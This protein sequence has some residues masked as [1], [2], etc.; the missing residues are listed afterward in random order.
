MHCMSFF[1]EHGSVSFYCFCSQMVTARVTVGRDIM[2]MKYRL[3]SGY[4]FLS[5]VITLACFFLRSREEQLRI[6]WRTL[7]TGRY[8]RG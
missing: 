7:Y 5:A 6:D 2:H 8:R 1:L 4:S 3:H